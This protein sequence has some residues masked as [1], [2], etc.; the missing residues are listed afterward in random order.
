MP[1]EKIDSLAD[2]VKSMVL[3]PA[4]A[5]FRNLSAVEAGELLKLL[6]HGAPRKPGQHARAA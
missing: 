6:K 3:I 5:T 2:D 1:P 4:D